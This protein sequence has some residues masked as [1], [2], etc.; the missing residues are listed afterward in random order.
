[1][2]NAAIVGL[3][4]WGKVLVNAIQGKSRKIRFVKATTRTLEKAEGFAQEHDLELVDGIDAILADRNTQAVVL[5][6]PHS[7]HASQ[8]E[9][10]ASAGKH[11]FVEKPLTLTV[12]SARAVVRAAERADIVLALGYNRRFHPN[13]AELRRWLKVDYL[14]TL[15]FCDC[16]LSAPNGMFLPKDTWRLNRGEAPAGALTGLGVHAIDSVI[17]LFGEI[18]D[19]HCRSVRR[20]IQNNTGDTTVVSLA[21][22]NGMVA[23]VSCS[24]AS[25]PSYRF[26]VYGSKGVAEITE[27]TL[28]NLH[29]S[30]ALVS[31]RIPEGHLN[32]IERPNI[33]TVRGA[34]EAFADS[35]D[36]VA[37]FPISH[38]QMIHG[39]A[40]FE[41]T[42]RSSVSGQVEKV[43]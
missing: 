39:V 29:F 5:A 34:L 38:S 31:E 12:E 33:D 30:S 9:R 19:V 32:M 25:A 16:V 11:V 6:T 10:A 43:L 1:V 36:G 27:P 2:I 7:H 20:V 18:E 23:C 40:A 17:D 41:A 42:V 22:K 28:E 4:W 35:I 26:A 8:I 15:L 13:M 14:G 3:G 21:L 24:I 37:P